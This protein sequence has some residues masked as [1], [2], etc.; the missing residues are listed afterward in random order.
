ME[1]LHTLDLSLLHVLRPKDHPVCELVAKL[2]SQIPNLRVL[3]APV[4]YIHAIDFNSSITDLYVQFGAQEAWVENKTIKN[5][6]AGIRFPK[7]RRL[8]VEYK[9]CRS[10]SDGCEKSFSPSLFQS[11]IVGKKSDL[12]EIDFRVIGPFFFSSTA[13]FET[14]FQVLSA[15]PKLEKVILYARDIIFLI[16][17]KMQVAVN[18]SD[19]VP[20]LHAAVAYIQTQPMWL[21]KLLASAIYVGDGRSVTL[22]QLAATHG[23]R[24]SI[25]QLLKLGAEV[26]AQNCAGMTAI[27]K[28]NNLEIMKLLLLNGAN[29]NLKDVHGETPLSNFLCNI[30]RPDM[31]D[32]IRSSSMPCQKQS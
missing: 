17:H 4:Y 9:H 24:S 19:D 7:L 3:H 28:T 6:D 8:R 2:I 21:H 30:S 15:C 12:V 16:Q 25:E 11:D 18:F 5:L 31:S 22:L 10:D 14:G 13:D 1:H 26:N 23:D 32:H 29:P 27:S 20:F